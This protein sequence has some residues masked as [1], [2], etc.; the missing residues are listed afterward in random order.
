M[1]REV[2]DTL[3]QVIFMAYYLHGLDPKEITKMILLELNVSVYCNGWSYL[4]DAII[5]FRK[6]A[7]QN[8]TKELYPSV[9]AR[10]DRG[11]TKDQVERSIRAAINKAWRERDDTIWRRY[12]SVSNGGTIKRPTN[13]E[14]I[15]RIAATIDLWEVCCQ[16]LPCE[17]GKR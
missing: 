7:K 13:A 9:A 8:I 1:Q 17:S 2:D 12:F 15:S 16:V 3:A 5:Q 6:D 4:I 10:F 14:F 11:V